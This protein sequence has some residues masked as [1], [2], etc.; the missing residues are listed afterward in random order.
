[1]RRSRVPWLLDHAIV[2]RVCDEEVAVS[3]DNDCARKTQAVIGAV[4][5]N[6]WGTVEG[7]VLRVCLQFQPRLEISVRRI[8]QVNKAAVAGAHI[9]A[10]TISHPPTAR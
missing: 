1:M 7:T 5:H 3:I 9:S 2:D 4:C 8:R 6:R 10:P